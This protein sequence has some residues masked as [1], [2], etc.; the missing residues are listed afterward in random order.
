MSKP[1]TALE[2]IFLD[3]VA[4]DEV[5][6]HEKEVLAYIKHR[7]ERAGAQHYQDKTGNIIA[8]I[9]G[10]GG[11]VLALCGHVDIAAP[12]GGRQVV[13][14]D[15]SIKTDGTG[16]LGADDKSAVAVMLELADRVHSGQLKLA[17]PV[18]LIFTVGEEA[19]LQGANGLDTTLLSAKQVL[20]F[21]GDGPVTDVISKSPSYYS[22]DIEY[23]GLAAHPAE[24]SKGINAGAALI[25]AANQFKMGEYEPGVTSNI[26][27]FSFGKARN[28]IP[29]SASLKAE[30]RSHDKQKLERAVAQ[31]TDLFVRVAGVHNVTM[32]AYE[33]DEA[34][35]LFS[36]AQ[37]AFSKLSLRSQ[38]IP[39][40][41]G[42]DGNILAG[43]G[44]EVM[45]F[46]AAYYDAHSI[47]ESLNRAEFSQLFEF[48]SCMV[49]S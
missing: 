16:L 19:G 6:P 27:I 47:N 14:D 30:M 45:I 28:Q 40:Y 31:V 17:R 35:E 38:L 37:A 25:D 13:I 22:L 3:L 46:G 15:T 26:G 20:V 8:S 9:A 23:I 2:Q 1:I 12:L 32:P 34:S 33:L 42:F 43:K 7:L 41:G 21:D 5:H 44:L 24:W 39:T 36:R 4:I 10:E 18:Q 29:G 48:V 11:Q 49:S